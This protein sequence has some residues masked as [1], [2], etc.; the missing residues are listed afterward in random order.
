MSNDT[1]QQCILLDRRDNTATALS[2]LEPG[3]TVRL[4]TGE[5]GEES[6]EGEAGEEG[7]RAAT[8]QAA[9]EEIV[10]R[11]RIP[12]AHKFARRPI[13]SGEDVRKYGQVIGVATADIEAGD[14]VHVH[15]IRGKRA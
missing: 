15:N 5:A 13:S 2:D 11:D 4:V 1:E 14:H 6:E 12:Y 7:D 8:A 3:V 9:V 10:I